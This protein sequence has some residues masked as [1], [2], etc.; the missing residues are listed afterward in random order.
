M[1]FAFR[2]VEGSPADPAE[3]WPYEALVAAIERGTISDWLV[4]I[5]AIERRP[6]GEVARRVEAYLGYA[7]P[8]GVGPLLRRAIARARADTEARERQQVAAEVRALARRS[9]LT[10]ERFARAIGT[11]RSR[12]STY[13][14]G[15]VVPAATLMVRMR[16]AAGAT[17]S[18]HDAHDASPAAWPASPGRRTPSPERHRR[19]AGRPNQQVGRPGSDAQLKAARAGRATAAQPGPP[20]TSVEVATRDITVVGRQAQ[21]GELVGKAKR[22]VDAAQVLEV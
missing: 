15:K 8:H 3:R 12:L 17:D 21:V 14:S 13:A 6:W 1:T 16:E 11:S 7:S 10:S 18:G 20:Q 22:G 19:A 4:L 2:N 5:R 9:G